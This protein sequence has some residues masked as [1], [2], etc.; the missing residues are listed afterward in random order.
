MDQHL[1]TLTMW[2]PDWDDSDDVDFENRSSVSESLRR[3]VKSPLGSKVFTTCIPFRMK[4]YAFGHP[5][6]PDGEGV[7]TSFVREVRRVEPFGKTAAYEF[8]TWSDHTYIIELEHASPTW[9]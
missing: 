9:L 8:D 5:K 2:S 6:Y 1:I 3:F 7:L 4:G